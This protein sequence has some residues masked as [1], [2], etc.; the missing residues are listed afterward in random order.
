MN[1]LKKIL[2]L[3]LIAAVVSLGGSGCKGKSEH[4][5]NEHPSK[6]APAKEASPN[7]PPAAEHPAGEHPK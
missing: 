3:V 7:E 1:K 4:P 2:V 6:Q 5:T